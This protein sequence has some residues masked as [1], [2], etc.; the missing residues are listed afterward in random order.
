MTDLATT[1]SVVIG[2]AGQVGDLLAELLEALGPVTSVDPVPATRAGV[3]SV[4]GDACA[5]SAAVLDAIGTADVVVFALPEQVAVDAL[6]ACAGAVRAGALLVEVLSVK[7]AIT[8]VLAS[9]AA[10]AGAEACGLNP[11]FAPAL[12]FAGHAVATVRVADGP[13]TAALLDLVTAAGA[14]VVEVSAAAHD[15]IGAVLQAA[16]HAALLAFGRVVV[17]RDAD[18][19]VL[20]DLAPPPHLAMLALA[21][22]IGGGSPDVYWDIQAA[23]P[24]AP[25]ARAALGAAVAELDDIA[26]RGDR[27]RFTEWMRRID[28]R[29]G[30]EGPRLRDLCARMFRLPAR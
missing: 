5:P 12:G 24:A 15:R 19:P 27:V 26:R 3:R 16:T 2:G 1:R 8:P 30:A 17:D 11:M 28:D 7:D 18:L 6:T 13:R 20:L 25:A 4:G 29:L 21:A 10:A 14:R 23:N 22:R 9:V